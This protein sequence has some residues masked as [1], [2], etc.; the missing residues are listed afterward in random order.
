[1]MTK[2]NKHILMWRPGFRVKQEY[3]KK[4]MQHLKHY[5]TPTVLHK[6]YADRLMKLGFDCKTWWWLHHCYVR[7]LYRDYNLEE[8]ILIYKDGCFV[9]CTILL[10]LLCCMCCWR[11]LDERFKNAGDAQE[12]RQKLKVG[13]CIVDTNMSVF[14]TFMHS[15]A[16]NIFWWSWPLWGV[17]WLV[18]YIVAMNKKER[19]Q[20]CFNTI[21]CIH[22]LTTV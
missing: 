1:M 6:F 4:P 14:W 15:F 5:N 20:N 18:V 8:A 12:R 3:Y 10:T 16:K 2:D 13:H 11:G 17:R 21:W 9:Y 22:M 19:Y 7:L